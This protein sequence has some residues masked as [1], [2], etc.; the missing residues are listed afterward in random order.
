MLD[1]LRKLREQ[2]HFDIVVAHINHMIRAN[3]ILDEEYV[4][5]YCKKHKIPFYFKRVDVQK[6][7]IME[8]KGT[9]EM[10]R[11]VRYTFFSEVMK[12]TVTP[13]AIIVHIKIAYF[14]TIFTD[15]FKSKKTMIPKHNIR[16]LP[17]D[18]LAIII[19][20]IGK[21]NKQNQKRLLLHFKGFLNIKYSNSKRNI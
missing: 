21:N 7:A 15:G 19:I 16:K 10:G 18:P 9:E 11:T 4:R 3:A 13:I 2:L 17:L 12:E 8:K 14:F 6:Q 20:N 1:V 5:Q